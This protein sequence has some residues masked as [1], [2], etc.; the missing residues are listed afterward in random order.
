MVSRDPWPGKPF[1]ANRVLT[2][3][4]LVGLHIPLLNTLS[5]SHT[6]EIK[7]CNPS[8]VQAPSFGVGFGFGFRVLSLGV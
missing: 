5:S 7:V 1:N 2:P 3:R 4:I 6:Y 8:I